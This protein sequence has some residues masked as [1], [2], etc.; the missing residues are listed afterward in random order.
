MSFPWAATEKD[1]ASF[2]M[3]TSLSVLLGP[4][5]GKFPSH[6]RIHVKGAPGDVTIPLTK[7]W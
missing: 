6:Q 1:T 4:L 5:W 2:D 7:G 3:I